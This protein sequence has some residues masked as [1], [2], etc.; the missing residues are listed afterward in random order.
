M[1]TNKAL[2]PKGTYFLYKDDVL[3]EYKD[4]LLGGKGMTILKL[5]EDINLNFD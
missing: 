5:R 4:S 1:K 2:K 3:S